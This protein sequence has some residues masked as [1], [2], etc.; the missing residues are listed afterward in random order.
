MITANPIDN[1]QILL[2]E[3]TRTEEQTE[4]AL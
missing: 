1:A 2:R 3:I 4:R